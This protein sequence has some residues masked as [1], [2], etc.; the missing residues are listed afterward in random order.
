MVHGRARAA[1]QRCTQLSLRPARS[2]RPRRRK[3]QNQYAHQNRHTIL[4]LKKEKVHFSLVGAVS[5]LQPPGFLGGEGVQSIREL[6]RCLRAVANIALVLLVP[7]SSPLAA[8][9][10]SCR[11]EL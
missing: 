8:D 7:H 11:N 4:R 6:E 5:V 9:G 2:G 3:N 1:R 10:E